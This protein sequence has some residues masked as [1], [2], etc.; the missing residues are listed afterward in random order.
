[1]ASSDEATAFS[2]LKPVSERLPFLK[3]GMKKR[4]RED[5]EEEE[6]KAPEPKR[7]KREEKDAE[8]EKTV[9]WLYLENVIPQDLHDR[10]LKKFVEEMEGLPQRKGKIMG[11]EYLEPRISRTF[12]Y[13]GHRYAYAG[14]THDSYDLFKETELLELKKLIQQI[15]KGSDDPLSYHDFNTVLVNLYRANS[16]ND[17]VMKHRDD[18]GKDFT[19]AS[20]SFGGERLFRIYS[21]DGTKGAPKKRVAEFMIKPR[22]L[23]LMFEGMQEK[24]KHE[25]VKPKDTPKKYQCESLKEARINTTFRYQV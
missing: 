17:G 6:I 22:S 23:L 16:P 21:D 11:K 20:V 2:F 12:T 5:G 10:I 15:T 4:E 7:A 18:D 25:I 8:D 9:P 14:V 1:M 19:I 24:Y 13:D 3:A